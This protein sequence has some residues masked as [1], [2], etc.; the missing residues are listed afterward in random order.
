M[1]YNTTG[2]INYSS[3]EGIIHVKGLIIYKDNASGKDSARSQFIKST[4]FWWN[5]KTDAYIYDDL[6]KL[7]YLL[8]ECI[9]S[10]LG[11]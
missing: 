4:T 2:F 11:I 8:K 10:L 3:D 1:F 5:T 6:Q 7:P 9:L